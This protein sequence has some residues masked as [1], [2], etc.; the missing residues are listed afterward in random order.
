MRLIRK[1]E[2]RYV[3]LFLVSPIVEQI[4]NILYII[5]V[6]LF[7]YKLLYASENFSAYKNNE[8]TRNILKE[9]TFNNITSLPQ[10]NDYLNSLIDTLYSNKSF[11]MLV[12]ITS[13]QIKKFSLSVNCNYTLC[14]DT[15]NNP[16]SIYNII[17]I[18]I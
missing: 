18:N 16:Q 14:L 5:T 7:I 11:P 17:Y 10:F 8:L 6:P 3:K 12:P 13:I 4:L 1:K 9:E 15:T 2:I